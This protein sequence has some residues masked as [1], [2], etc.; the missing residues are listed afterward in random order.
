MEGCQP[1][2]I[3]SQAVRAVTCVAL[4]RSLTACTVQHDVTR[5]SNLVAETEVGDTCRCWKN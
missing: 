1:H 4:V 2:E 5:G 3:R